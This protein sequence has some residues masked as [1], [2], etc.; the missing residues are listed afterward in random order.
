MKISKDIFEKVDRLYIE[1]VINEK[2]QQLQEKFDDFIP[3]EK[4]LKE[5]LKE[6][7]KIEDIIVA[8]FLVGT[9]ADY[10]M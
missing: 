1:T 9:I 8:S 3:T 4:L 2:E 5:V 10:E 7:D 6:F